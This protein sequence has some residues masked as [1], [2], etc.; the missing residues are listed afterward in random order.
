MSNETEKGRTTLGSVVEMPSNED[1]EKAGDPNAKRVGTTYIIPSTMKDR[2]SL[3]QQAKAL[4]KRIQLTAVSLNIVTR[5]I[6]GLLAKTLVRIEGI[7]PTMDGPYYATKITHKIRPGPYTCSMHVCRS[8]STAVAH[9]V[10][11]PLPG[12]GQGVETKGNVNN[13]PTQ[14]PETLNPKKNP[15]GSTEFVAPGRDINF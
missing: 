3:E 10:D 7:G 9:P 5:G 12:Q 2:K 6:P 14:D 8:A 13:K 1:G 15:D 11:E 4:F